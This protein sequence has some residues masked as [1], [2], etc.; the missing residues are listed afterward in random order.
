MKSFKVGDKVDIFFTS[1]SIDGVPSEIRD[2][3][4]LHIPCATGDLL[5]VTN[6]RTVFAIN[7]GS[8]AFD[9]MIKS[10]D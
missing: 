5:E 8:S 3:E 7:T 9:Q 2:C 10:E 4:I 6:G 1:D